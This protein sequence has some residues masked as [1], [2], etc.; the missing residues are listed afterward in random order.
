MFLPY[1]RRDKNGYY[2]TPWQ[3]VRHQFVL[4]QRTVGKSIDSNAILLDLGSSQRIAYKNCSKFFLFAAVAHMIGLN[5]PANGPAS[6][7][8]LGHIITLP[9][10]FLNFF[11]AFCYFGILHIVI[12]ALFMGE[13]ARIAAI[14]RFNQKNAMPARISHDI[15]GVWSMAITPFYGFLN[16]GRLHSVFSVLGMVSI[17]LP[18]V[19]VLLALAAEVLYA[20]VIELST[21]G[22][23]SV[24]GIMSVSSV[25][26]VLFSTIFSLC[27]FFPFY[28]KRNVDFVRWNFLFPLL[29]RG[30]IFSPRVEGWMS[31]APASK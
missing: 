21:F 30:A 1:N 22:P 2:I 12:S 28:F 11:I 17:F 29:Y 14:K 15:N 13:F 27:V 23:F 31:S 9:L 20:S 19:L 24:L 4:W 5:S 26:L 8:V 6:V 7:T 10:G 16:S 25:L 3:M 18:F